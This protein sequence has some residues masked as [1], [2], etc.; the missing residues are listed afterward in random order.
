MIQ[1]PQQ[2][3]QQQQQP[4]QHP[5][6]RY[7]PLLTDVTGERGNESCHIFWE[8][9]RNT[10]FDIRITDTEAPSYRNQDFDKVL[11]AHEK[12]KKEKHLIPLHAQR[13][14][15]TPIVY[16]VDGIAGR[17]AKSDEKHLTS[18]LAAPI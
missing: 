13:K 8:R 14:D 15:F 10:I 3:Q 9:G 18:T 2:L 5:E 11:A 7:A 4:H 16:S 6:S 17:E 1:Q 12:D